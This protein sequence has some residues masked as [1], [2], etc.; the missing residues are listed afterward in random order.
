[1]KQ[2]PFEKPEDAYAKL[3]LSL[4]IEDLQLILQLLS[5]FFNAIRVVVWLLIFWQIETGIRR[6]W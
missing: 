4:I 3:K 6:S 5:G 2:T 1:M